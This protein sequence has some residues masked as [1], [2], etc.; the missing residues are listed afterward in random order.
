MK[1]YW[2]VR[3]DDKIDGFGWLV[4]DEHMNAISLTELDGNEIK[5]GVSYTPIEF[6]TKPEWA[7]VA[8]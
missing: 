1:T 6:D 7:D 4:F 3:F 2:K 8:D 5:E